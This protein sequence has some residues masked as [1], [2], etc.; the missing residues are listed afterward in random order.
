MRSGDSL[1]VVVRAADP[2][3]NYIRDG[4]ATARVHA[5]EGSAHDMELHEQPAAWDG[6]A[7]GYVAFIDTTGWPPGQYVLTGHVTGLRG[8]RTVRGTSAPAEFTISSPASD[9]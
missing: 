1:R 6:R 8:V 5:A 2:D 9:S 4:Q 3:G 7:R